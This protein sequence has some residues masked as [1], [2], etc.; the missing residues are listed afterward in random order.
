MVGNATGNDSRI[1]QKVGLDVDRDAVEGHPVSYADAD[2]GDLVFAR[3]AV[4]QRRFV[5]PH[6]PDADAAFPPFGLDVEA[7]QRADRP[8]LEVGNVTPYVLAARPKVEHHISH[9]LAGAVIGVLAA[10]ARDM[11]RKAGGLKQI[12]GP[13]A[14]TGRI[15]RRM[16]QQPDHFA[17]PAGADVGDP[18]FHGGERLV[19]GDEAVG[20]APFEPVHCGKIGTSRSSCK[21]AL[22]LGGRFGIPRA[23]DRRGHGGIGRRAS[24]RC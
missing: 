4:G 12:L 1:V 13:R 2:G 24:L 3:A 11:D 7:A 10:A 15:E 17:R 19:V 18:R 6:D 16:L 21:P 5:R 9:P 20:D 23:I 14:R 22:P 8:F